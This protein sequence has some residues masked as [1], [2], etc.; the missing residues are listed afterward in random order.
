[1]R[2]NEHTITH[3]STICL[4][5]LKPFCTPSFHFSLINN[6][7]RE[8]SHKT[9]S[10]IILTVQKLSQEA[11]ENSEKIFLELYQYTERKRSE[12][13]EMILAQQKV[14]QVEG[15]LQDLEQRVSEMRREDADLTELLQEEDHVHFLQVG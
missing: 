7:E 8:A 4:F 11:L 13:R 6:A 10:S 3:H 2:N 9:L 14:S 5:C 1:M 12:E 15:V